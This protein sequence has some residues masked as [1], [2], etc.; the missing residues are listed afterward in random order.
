MV[1]KILTN[2]QLRRA[3]DMERARIKKIKERDALERQLKNLRS[4]G[5]TDVAGRIGRGFV[6]LSKKAGSA[7]LKQAKL[8]RER[9]I[10][11][12]AR[13]KKKK[14]KSNGVFDPIGTLDM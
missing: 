7:A 10:E 3:I 14:K 12:D 1:K 8:I 9:Q 13:R 2:K 6:V 11:D 4:S 5:R